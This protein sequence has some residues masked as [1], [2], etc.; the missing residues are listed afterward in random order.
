MHEQRSSVRR[1]THRKVIVYSDDQQP[2]Y[3]VIQDFSTGGLYVE[4]TSGPPA[5]DSTVKLSLGT[6]N[7]RQ[8]LAM[9]LQG[10]VVRQEQ[11][12]IGMMFTDYDEATVESLRQLYHSALGNSAA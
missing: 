3:G 1:I 5:V 11:E 2:C 10:V 6:T 12:G 4:T 8:N 9:Q 7:P